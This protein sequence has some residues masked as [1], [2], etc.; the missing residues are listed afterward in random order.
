MKNAPV[1]A[2]W[3]GRLLVRPLCEPAH[4]GGKLQLASVNHVAGRNGHAMHY[5]H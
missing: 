1:T 2:M 4:R 3:Q 5:A